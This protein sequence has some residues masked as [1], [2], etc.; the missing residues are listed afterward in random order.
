MEMKR[1]IFSLQK[2][3]YYPTTSCPSTETQK[4][5]WTT[6][7][8]NV[9]EATNLHSSSMWD[10]PFSSSITLSESGIQK[11]KKNTTVNEWE[12]CALSHVEKI[13]RIGLMWCS[14][15]SSKHN[16]IKF[17]SLCTSIHSTLT[18]HYDDIVSCHKLSFMF[19]SKRLR[20]IF[21]LSKLLNILSDL[22]SQLFQ[23]KENEKEGKMKENFTALH[24]QE[25]RQNKRGQNWTFKEWK[26]IHFW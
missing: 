17:P 9:I 22:G 12:V 10:V 23:H 3:P 18:F 25:K 1:N 6:L 8:V 2:T 20:K 24:Q 21:S 4:C 7:F 15:Y 5:S 14:F 13:N 16:Q 11:K 19:Q 26:A